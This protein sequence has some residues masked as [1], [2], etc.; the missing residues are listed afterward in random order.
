VAEIET[1]RTL[2]EDVAEA[3]V[4]SWRKVSGSVAQMENKAAELA[5]KFYTER[6]VIDDDV[7]LIAELEEA[8]CAPRW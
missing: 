8:H 7:S 1:G 5:A 4:L 6:L 2:T 3:R